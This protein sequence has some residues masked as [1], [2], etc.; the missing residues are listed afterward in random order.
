MILIYV[1]LNVYAQKK[2]VPVTISVFSEATAVPFTVLPLKPLHPG[3]SA[4]TELNYMHKRRNRLFQSLQLSY[5][6]HQYL[7]QAV[8]L[9]TELGYE[10]R[11][12]IGMAAS[13][14]LGIGYMRNF[15]TATEYSFDNGSYTGKWG[16]GVGRLTPS[17]SV[18]CAYYLQ[19]FDR[20]SP[21]LFVRYQS[22]AEYPYAPGFIPLMTH[23]NM[24]FGTKIFISGHKN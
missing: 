9:Q 4:G 14:M 16:S 11:S 22:W 24:H 2:P 13:A 23:V 6:Y 3:I 8:T 19:K 17:F 1:N 10:Y 20:Y 21:K 18:E 7:N 15:R 12:G 5:Y